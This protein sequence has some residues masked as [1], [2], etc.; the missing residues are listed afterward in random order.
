MVNNR[1]EVDAPAAGMPQTIICRG[2]I[3]LNPRKILL[4]LL[5]AMT[6]GGGEDVYVMA[7]PGSPNP[8]LVSTRSQKAIRQALPG[9]P[10]HLF[11]IEGWPERDPQ[12]SYLVFG[13]VVRNTRSVQ[14]FQTG[15]EPAG[16]MTHAIWECPAHPC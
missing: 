14:F 7:R 10:I 16:V 1:M 4:G 13:P 3:E 5:G 8:V 9:I 15:G 2:P 11:L 6:W 12:W